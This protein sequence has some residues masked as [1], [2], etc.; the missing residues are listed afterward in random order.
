MR[1]LKISEKL[2]VG[3]IGQLLLGVL[4]VYFFFNLSNTMQNVT[5]QRVQSIEQATKLRKLTFLIK[6]Y[7]NKKVSYSEMEQMYRSF[8]TEHQNTTYL[9]DFKGIWNQL[10]RFQ[11]L[12]DKNLEINNNLMQETRNSIDQSNTYITD[13]STK[14][15]HPTL[16]NQVSVLERQVIMGAN[17]NGNNNYTIR[18]LF[19]K[20][21]EDISNLN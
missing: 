5:E 16:R 6:D 4:I 21:K 13:V 15:A 3:I 20:V 12:G 2:L 17:A 19:Y 8:E 7:F 1:N 10:T 18:E 9:N 14:L 11:E